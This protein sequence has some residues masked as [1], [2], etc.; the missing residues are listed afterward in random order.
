MILTALTTLQRLPAR[1]QVLPGIPLLLHHHLVNREQIPTRALSTVVAFTAA[2]EH[3]RIS[4]CAFLLAAINLAFAAFSACWLLM[5]CVT[6][7]SLRIVLGLLATLVTCT[8]RTNLSLT[9]A[10]IHRR[11]LVKTEDLGVELLPRMLRRVHDQVIF[12]RSRIQPV[13]DHA[14]S[15]I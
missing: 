10:H 3:I 1:L 9:S 12:Q 11:D 2:F 15:L 7:R 5:L 6:R 8:L 4:C 14:D 13:R